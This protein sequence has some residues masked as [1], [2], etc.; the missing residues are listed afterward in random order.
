MAIDTVLDDGR[1]TTE[2]GRVEAATTL[3]RKGCS[4][5]DVERLT[6]LSLV[7]LIVVRARMAAAPA[8]E[9]VRRAPQHA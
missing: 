3:F 1:T 2:L 4:D 5:E 7:E 9:R 6:G 8:C